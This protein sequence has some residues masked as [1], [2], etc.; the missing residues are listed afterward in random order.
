MSGFAFIPQNLTIQRG[1]TV[2]WNNVDPVI[3]TLWFV[4]VSDGSTYLL[5]DPLYPEAT[6][7]YTFTESVNLRYYSFERL[8]ITS[9]L[10]LSK[11]GDLD[12]DGDVDFLDLFLFVNAYTGEYNYLADF[13]GNGVIDY[14][15][16][17]DFVNY[18][19]TG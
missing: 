14:L 3:Y 6:W 1:D 10:A 16:L 13:D 17:F 7:S 5:S 4:K 8:W 15:D 11:P 18:Y 12:S 9:W 19:A 2:V